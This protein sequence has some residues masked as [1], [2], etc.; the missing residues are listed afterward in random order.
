MANEQGR[1][2]GETVIGTIGENVGLGQVLYCTPVSGPA[3]SDLQY[4]GIWKVASADLGDLYAGYNPYWQQTNPNLNDGWEYSSSSTAQLGIAV[5]VGTYSTISATE[6]GTQINILLKGYYSPGY[7]QD[8]LF[9]QKGYCDGNITEGKPVFLMPSWVDGAATDSKGVITQG[10]PLPLSNYTWNG[11]QTFSSPTGSV[12]L[13]TSCATQSVVRVLGYAYDINYPYVIRFEP[14][15]SW[16]EFRRGSTSSAM[17]IRLN[18]T[19]TING[20]T[21]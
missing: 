3:P 8:P 10:Q 9:G 1:Y 6:S 7:L 12:V 5:E 2:I 13:K 15:K 17:D 16:Y 4:K 14:E 11:G 20:F 19:V 18:G 21:P